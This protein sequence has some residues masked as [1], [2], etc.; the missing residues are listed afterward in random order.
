M[1]KRF[2]AALRMT[3]VCYPLKCEARRH[4]LAQLALVISPMAKPHGSLK[5]PPALSFA[6]QTAALLTSS[7]FSLLSSF[8]CHVRI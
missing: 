1:R 7:F 6:T 5:A 4:V 3:A 2:F 8:L